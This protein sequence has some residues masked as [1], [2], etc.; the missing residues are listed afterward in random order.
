V[1][2][3]RSAR[4]VTPA[5][6]ATYAGI[7][8]LICVALGFLTSCGGSS[9]PSP[10]SISEANGTR[11]SAAFGEAFAEPLVATVTSNG[12]P[13]AGVE[14]TFTAPASGASGT[15]AN[16]EA[17]ETDTTGANGMATSTTFTANATVGGPYTVTA[18]V[19]GLSVPASFS[20]TNTAR[21]PTTITA[22]SGS[23]QS[24]VILFAFA[25]PLVATVLD[26]DSNP[27]SG[28]VVTFTAPTS[29]ATGWFANGKLTEMVT[30]DASGKATATT[31]WANDRVGTYTVTASI[32]GV[33][34]P[35]SF[36]LR[37]IMH[38]EVGPCR[39]GPGL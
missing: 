17:T 39:F 8:A 29:E 21:V 33:S 13:A 9:S 18:L 3:N 16:G 24:A 32:A 28:V 35:A 36:S 4:V 30:T 11:Q 6:F 12:T 27:V 38:C 19:T 5:P 34:M 15:F 37:N 1:K 7:P 20:L 25:D 31:F 26:S 10:T 23:G 14:V 22:T 2:R